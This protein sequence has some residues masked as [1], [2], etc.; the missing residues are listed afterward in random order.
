[1]ATAAPRNL[2]VGTILDKMFAVIERSMAAS[3]IYFVVLGALNVALGYYTLG[4]I[5]PLPVLGSAAL[6]FV[7]G[8]IAAF[9][10]LDAM[11]GNTGLRSR[12]DGDVFLS[13]LVL[14]VIYTICLVL[15][16]IVIVLPGLYIMARW[17]IAQPLLV[18]R[19]GSPMK[20]L[21]ES[22]ERTKDK[23]FP[24]LLA[25][26]VVLV[27]VIAITIVC[28][29]MLGR[30]NLTGMIISQLTSSAGGVLALAM[31]VAILGLLDSR[32]RATG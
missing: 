4:V 2:T 25:L 3:L 24:I 5:A 20:A 6:K 13:Y 11:V 31:G 19:G 8:V 26:L 15:G 29:L 7:I 27:P 32:E 21:G 17:I 22:W 1:M 30:D 16:F 18:A 12:T 10:V 28:T 9:F 23:E 14:S